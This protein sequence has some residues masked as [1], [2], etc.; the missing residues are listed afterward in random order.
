M[1][2]LTAAAADTALDNVTFTPTENGGPGLTFSTDITVTVND[3]G[4]GG[5]Q[6]VLAPTTLTI[7]RINDDPTNAGSLPTDITA[8][9]DV[10]SDVDLSL[11]DLADIDANGGS[12]TIT[13][14]TGAGGTLAATSGGGVTVGGSGTGVL[15]LDG[16]IT[17]LNNF[18]DI[19]SNIQFIGALN[20]T[21][22]DIDTI[23]VD[24]TD[25]G[26]LGVGGGGTINLGTVNVDISPANDDPTNTGGLPSDV[27][28][29]EDLA[30]NID[31]SAIDLYDPD[32]A[33]AALTMTLSTTSGG[34]LDAISG[35]GV[36]VTGSG[37]GTITLSG[38]Q[39]ALNAYLDAVTNIQYTGVTD[40]NGNDID[41][42]LITITDNGNVGVGGGGTIIIGS[43]N[44]D[45]TAVN[46]AP[47]ATSDN[48]NVN[49]GDTLNVA[50]TGVLTNDGDIEGDPLTAILVTGP[51]NG[52]LSLAADGSLVYTPDT[53]FF[54]TDSFFYQASDGLLPSNTVEVQ[55]EVAARAPAETTDPDPEPTPKPETEPD[56]EPEPEPETETESNDESV[57]ETVGTGPAPDAT[58]VN[59]TELSPTM[60]HGAGTAVGR[61]QADE[62][63]SMVQAMHRGLYMTRELISIDNQYSPHAEMLERLLQMDL[64]QAIVWQM[65]D[66]SRDFF[67]NYDPHYFVGSASVATGL[68]SVGYVMW[69]LRGG[70]FMTAIA[71][72]IPSWRLIDP[73]ALLATYKTSAVTSADRIEKIFGVVMSASSFRSSVET[74]TR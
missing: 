41:S 73:S 61:A 71:S 55:I 38:D 26:N 19:A 52:T 11:I 35:G 25:N 70:A 32:S 43:T 53:G 64:E 18:L 23:Q 51:A 31:L 1:T 62:Q 14:S 29:S 39:T 57:I 37:S 50:A 34:T 47:V 66:E 30:S 28:V 2:G 8:G 13:L 56:Q 24:V 3:Q 42:I 63:D 5:E 6:I 59:A 20:A 74:S 49:A 68:F 46:D 45:V 22:N 17:D 33:S 9:E 44:V 48:F 27:T 72:S 54:G 40:A 67:E 69:A 65:W 4:G 12:L 7:T 60:P 10:A 58:V 21:G 15:T 16:T 36:A